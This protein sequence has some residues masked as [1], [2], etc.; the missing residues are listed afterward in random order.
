[1]KDRKIRISMV[2][3]WNKPPNDCYLFKILNN[4]LRSRIE[5]N[6][7]NPP[8]IVISFGFG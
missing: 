6:T 1:M 7:E 2:D 5:L 8:D 3:Y 4:E